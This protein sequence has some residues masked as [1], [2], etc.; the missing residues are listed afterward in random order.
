MVSLHERHERALPA[1]IEP[2]RHPRERAPRVHRAQPLLDESLGV[3]TR[4]RVLGFVLVVVDGVVYTLGQ[5][6]IE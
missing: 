5:N 3:D 2:L 4:D 1:C 6:P